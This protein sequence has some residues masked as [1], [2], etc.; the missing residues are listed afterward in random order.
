MQLV[1]FI[2]AEK[3]LPV[4]V[5]KALKK[6]AAI[7][8]KHKVNVKCKV[9][10]KYLN[11]SILVAFE[12]DCN[13]VYQHLTPFLI[14]L[15]TPKGVQSSIK[16]PIINK[17]NQKIYLQPKTLLGLVTPQEQVNVTKS[18]VEKVKSDTERN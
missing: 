12:V 18:T 1:N 13:K 15:T 6:H 8:P 11:I 10:S 14:V 3:F 17:S 16:V 7:P 9:E 5:V 4:L 2:H